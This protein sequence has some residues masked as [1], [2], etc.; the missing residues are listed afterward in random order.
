MLPNIARNKEEALRASLKALD[1]I[2]QNFSWH[3]KN[4]RSVRNPEFEGKFPFIPHSVYR[5]MDILLY[6]E[7]NWNAIQEKYSKQYGFTPRFSEYSQLSFL[8]AGCGVGNILIYAYS[9]GMFSKIMGLELDAQTYEYA[10]ILVNGGDTNH[11]AWVLQQDILTFDKYGDFDVIYYY[12]PF[13]D[14][15]KESEFESLVE[16]QAKVG[17]IIIPE[18][19]RSREFLS[20]KKFEFVTAQDDIIL[21]VK[22]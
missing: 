21:K 6:L 13:S 14:V 8:D 10:K 20:S 17:A 3:T 2:F 9:L 12:C 18:L 7:N 5:T 11:Y 16:E 22:E 4:G 15:E 19:K 1:Q